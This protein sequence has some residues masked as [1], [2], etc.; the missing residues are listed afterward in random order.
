MRQ[1]PGAKVQTSPRLFRRRHARGDHD[2]ATGSR[3]LSAAGAGCVSRSRREVTRADLLSGPT[4]RDPRSEQRQAAYPADEH[5]ERPG[6]ERGHASQHP[7]PRS[8]GARSRGAP[9][10]TGDLRRRRRGARHGPP[11]DFNLY[12]S[13]R[14]LAGKGWTTYTMFINP[15]TP[16]GLDGYTGPHLSGPHKQVSDDALTKLALENR[17]GRDGWLTP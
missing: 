5:R 13:Y 11:A 8:T 9:R 1:T 4:G 12:V 10:E 3:S 7:W 6:A 17:P 14:D 16:G 2:L 15:R